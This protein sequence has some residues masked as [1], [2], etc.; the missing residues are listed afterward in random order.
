MSH[1]FIGGFL[2]YRKTHMVVLCG[3]TPRPW[4]YPLVRGYTNLSFPYAST[5]YQ[6]KPRGGYVSHTVVIRLMSWLCVVIHGY[7]LQMYRKGV[8]TT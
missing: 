2:T 6:E 1:P 3:Y 7:I 8:R 4:L 5:S